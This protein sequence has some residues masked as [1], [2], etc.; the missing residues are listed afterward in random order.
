VR[1][2]LTQWLGAPFKPVFGL[3]W[4]TTAL[5]QLLSL[6]A[7]PVL[8]QTLQREV[9]LRMLTSLRFGVELLPVFHT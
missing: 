4:D 5:D 1:L 6:Q 3:E 7:N 2:S 9:L 8:T